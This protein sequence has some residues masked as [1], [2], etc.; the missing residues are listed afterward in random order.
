VKELL[1]RLVTLVPAY[2]ADL[3]RL[4]TGPKRFLSKRTRTWTDGLLFLAV[5]FLL[6][7]VMQLPLSRTD[8]LLEGAAEAAFVLGYVVLYGYAVFFSWRA[9][10]GRAPIERFFAIHFYVAGVLKIIMSVTF[11]IVI[12]VLRMADPA[13]YEEMNKAVY[14]GNALWFVT[15]ADRLIDQPAW[16]SAMA[17]TLIGLSAMLAWL[18]TIWGAY[19][20]VNRLSRLRSTVAFVIF[21]A[22]CV[23]IYIVTSIIANALIM[24][25]GSSAPRSS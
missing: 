6:T 2:F 7:F 22:A 5:S 21:C 15:N 8:P 11:M 16:Q 23:P 4:T 19:R 3:L 13:A 10:G 9:V 14:A 20:E 17:I 18:W 1:E 24:E 25:G 12:G